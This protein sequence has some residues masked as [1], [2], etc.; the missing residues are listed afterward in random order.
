[1]IVYV[2]TS[3][4]YAVLDRD[5]ENH[6]IALELWRKLLAGSDELATTNY[7]VLETVALSQARLGIEAVR[8]FTTDIVPLLSVD[9]VGEDLHRAA[10]AALLTTAKRRLS[11]VDCV[12]F[13]AMRARGIRTA[14]TFDAHYS[15]HGFRPLSA[16]N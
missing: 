14:F 2:D 16:S 13:E 6:A 4:L 10:T 12:S 15:R 9:W 8:A 1:M 11:L 3:A 7:T 5:D